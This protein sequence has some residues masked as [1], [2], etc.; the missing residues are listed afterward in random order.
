[1]KTQFV[2]TGAALPA[3]QQAI[4]SLPAQ[5]VGIVNLVKS[6]TVPV[7]KSVLEAAI[8]SDGRGKRVLSYY[9]SK[10]VELGLIREEIADLVVGHQAAVGEAPSPL[11]S[12]AKYG[13]LG[14]S[15]VVVGRDPQGGYGVWL[16]EPQSVTR[17]G[18]VTTAAE[19]A[20]AL[21]N[22]QFSAT[23]LLEGQT[24][25]TAVQAVC[26][27]PIKWLG[28]KTAARSAASKKI[29]QSQ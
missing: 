13:T 23:H 11:V 1:M 3:E 6:A 26:G 5:A 14:R 9:K 24:D 19:S 27:K 22:L 4:D 16:F 7:E 20:L 8:S 12:V 29:L 15:A 10:L 2:Y 17:V 28:A 21:K 25:A 18:K